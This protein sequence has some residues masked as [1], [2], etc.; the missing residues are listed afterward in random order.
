MFLSKTCE[1]LEGKVKEQS[2][3][4]EELEEKVKAFSVESTQLSTDVSLDLEQKIAELKE[5]DDQIS[6]LQSQIS[7]V[8]KQLSEK[9]TLAQDALAYSDEKV[10]LLRSETE[11]KIE[12]LNEKLGEKASEIDALQQDLNLTKETL[13]KKT[14]ES[15][16]DGIDN[17]TQKREIEISVL[18]QSVSGLEAY[19]SEVCCIFV[20]KFVLFLFI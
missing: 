2:K 3:A 13:S 7:K 16:S 4:C 5:K 20:N 17:E 15:S 1:D 18:K 11:E 10:K 14:E 19:L 9:T 8:E 12:Q 6:E